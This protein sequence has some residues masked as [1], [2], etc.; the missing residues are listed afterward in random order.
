MTNALDT[1]LVEVGTEELPPLELPVLGAEFAEK[2]SL[3]LHEA[4]FAHQSYR[5]FYTPRRLAVQL[6]QIASRQEERTVRR[7]GPAVS[8]AYDQQG[9]PTK[10]ALGFA[11]ACGVTVE[12]LSTCEEKG[13]ERLVCITQQAGVALEDVM[14][15]LLEQVLQSLPMKRRMRWTEQT[16]AFVRP[17][18][19]LCVL[20][21]ERV[22]ACSVFGNQAGRD[23]YGHRFCSPKPVLLKHAELY[24]S[25][26]K[27]GKVIADFEQRREQ[28]ARLVD[29]CVTDA[30]VDM[31]AQS[32]TVM[33]AMTEWPQVISAGFDKDFLCLPKSVLVQILKNDLKVLPVMDPAD[34]LLPQFLI[35][36]NIESTR[37]EVIKS[38]Y[39]G[40]ARTRLADAMFFLEQDRKLAFAD[41]RLML[42]EIVFQEQLGTLADKVERIGQLAVNVA[43][44]CGADPEHAVTAAQLCKCDLTTDIVGEYPGLEGTMGQYYVHASGIADETV[45]VAIGE[46]YQPRYSGDR[47]P[48][49]P[50]GLALAL[51][52][53]MDTLTGIFGIKCSPTGTKDP[54]GLRRA[55]LGIV[56]I[57]VEKALPVNLDRF[58]TDSLDLY[59]DV[60][61][62]D[63][64][65]QQIFAFI[66]ERLRVY[67]LNEGFAFDCID[68]VAAVRPASPLDFVQRLH[69]ISRFIQMP[70]AV[71]LTM[72]NKRIVNL[73]SKQVENIGKVAPD[74]LSAAAEKDMLVM[75]ESCEAA[76]M[77]LLDQAQYLESIQVLVQLHAPIDRFFDEVL[78]MTEDAV[79]RQNRLALLARVGGLFMRIADFSRLD[80]EKNSR[81]A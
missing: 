8:R 72:A 24:T 38:G 28:I 51:A 56:R 25:K 2:L 73:V 18:R 76:L 4:G 79:Q 9:N 32:L 52:D 63:D 60:F 61:A 45:S 21:G 3:A 68:A 22:V 1:L 53:K 27:D 47:L 67:C 30:V 41:R 59:A 44:A 57:L 13:E 70:E 81:T 23:T 54:F 35:V 5:A 50:L 34:N 69:A 71:S 74:L 36:A 11:K 43:E 46:H 37:P 31:D 80:I 16:T 20:H 75:T 10:A 12:Q 78:V 29:A 39:E 64:C 55:A 58:I 6:L 15:Q 26:L 33:A 40:V 42:S 62:P 7:T 77:P 66:H 14:T 48:E 19:W 49:S 65:H 17:V